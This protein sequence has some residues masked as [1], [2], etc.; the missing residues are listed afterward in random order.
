MYVV[1]I[2]RVSD[3]CVSLDAYPNEPDPPISPAG[4]DSATKGSS[5]PRGAKAKANESFQGR[6]S[7][8]GENPSQSDLVPVKK[9][10]DAFVRIHKYIAPTLNGFSPKNQVEVDEAI[11]HQ[12]AL[13]RTWQ[14]VLSFVL[15]FNSFLFDSV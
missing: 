9:D 2:Q 8:D 14:H 11:V 6:L 3:S 13:E 15:Y 7:E 5:T 10:V 12:T 4:K 1:L